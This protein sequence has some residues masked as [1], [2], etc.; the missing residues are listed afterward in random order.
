MGI[1]YITIKRWLYCEGDEEGEKNKQTKTTQETPTNGSKSNW[2][3]LL[4][5][6]YKSWH[7]VTLLFLCAATTARTK[8]KY[9]D[10]TNFKCAL[11]LV[12][13]LLSCKYS[14][15]MASTTEYLFFLQ[16]PLGSLLL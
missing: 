16:L 14:R 2:S 3:S 1:C 8:E 5:T 7:D 15:N 10:A 9:C 4:L 12:L 13:L 11:F 6:A